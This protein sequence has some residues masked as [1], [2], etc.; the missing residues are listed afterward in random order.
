MGATK[1]TGQFYPGRLPRQPPRKGTICY[2]K[3]Q[4]TPVKLTNQLVWFLPEELATGC[5]CNIEE[6]RKHSD[7]VQVL[8]PTSTSH[9]SQEVHKIDH[10]INGAV[11][12]GYN[13]LHPWY[14]PE[15]VEPSKTSIPSTFDPVKDRSSHL[16]TDS[17]IGNSLGLS[18]ATEADS[19]FESSTSQHIAEQSSDQRPGR[20]EIFPSLA[21]AVYTVG[22]IC[23]LHEALM[24]ARVLFD[25][26]P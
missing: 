8:L 16:S 9:L 4:S 23:A 26:Y 20:M 25:S 7:I 13:S 10:G 19:G 5:E 21:T 12:F 11:I 3:L 1:R 17:G 14:W 6:G 15:T 22:I 2:D 24:A 18:A